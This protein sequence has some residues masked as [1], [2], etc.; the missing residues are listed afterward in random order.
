MGCTCLTAIVAQDETREWY[1]EYCGATGTLL[2]SEDIDLKQCED[3]GEP[4]VPG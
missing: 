3:C 2:P 4:V 1:C